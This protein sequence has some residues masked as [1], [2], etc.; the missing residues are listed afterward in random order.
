MLVLLWL[1]LVL[2]LLLLLLLIL[3]MLLL[4][5]VMLQQ[6]CESQPGAKLFMLRPLLALSWQRRG[7]SKQAG[8]G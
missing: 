1:L 4:V 6:Q 7:K 3:V 8:E 2:L 5:L